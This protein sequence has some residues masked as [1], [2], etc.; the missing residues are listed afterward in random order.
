MAISISVT[1]AHLYIGTL[2]NPTISLIEIRFGGDEVIFRILSQIKG[3]FLLES[4]TELMTW[5]VNSLYL[6]PIE[7]GGN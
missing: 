2:H 1:N 4:H 7:N 5:Q 3:V 6:N